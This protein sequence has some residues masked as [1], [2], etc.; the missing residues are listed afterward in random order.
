MGEV[1]FTVVMPAYNAEA[2]VADAI[3]SVLRQ[4]RQDFEIVV[5]DDGSSDSTAAR[6]AAFEREHR[7]RLIRQPS[8]P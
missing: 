8:L 4:S 2:T 6:V 3:R 5:V 1:T 7:V